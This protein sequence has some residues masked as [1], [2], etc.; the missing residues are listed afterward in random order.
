MIGVVIMKIKKLEWKGYGLFL[1]QWKV[2]GLMVLHSP[3][4]T[5][6]EKYK[7]YCNLPGYSLGFVNCLIESEA[8]ES[9]EKAV[10]LWLSEILESDE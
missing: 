5:T 4:D 3:Q 2:G 7:A 10:N 9:L 8:K 1:G 6:Q